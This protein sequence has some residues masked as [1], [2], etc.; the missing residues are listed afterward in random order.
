MKKLGVV[1]SFVLLICCCASV[2]CLM[3]VASWWR[4]PGPAGGKYTINPYANVS[5]DSLSVGVVNGSSAKR[6]IE[7]AI[8]QKDGQ[9]LL[10]NGKPLIVTD[11]AYFNPLSYK[12]D[13]GQYVQLIVLQRHT[14]GYGGVVRNNGKEFFKV[15]KID[16]VSSEA[17]ELELPKELE[18]DAN[19]DFYSCADPYLE[20]K[21]LIVNQ[22][23][24]MTSMEGHS[25]FAIPWQWRRIE[26]SI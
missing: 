26:I 15:I 22:G 20:D 10:L 6:P 7:L 5:S 12:R 21:K 4:V 19:G 14:Y 2:L 17:F 3:T 1:L 13:D 16:Y 9:P 11:Y 8:I 18:V 25:G 24:C 23:T